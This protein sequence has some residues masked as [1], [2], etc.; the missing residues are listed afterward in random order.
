MHVEPPYSTLGT[1]TKSPSCPPWAKYERSR[2]FSKSSHQIHPGL[3]VSHSDG[4]VR[5]GQ[6]V[7]TAVP[8]RPALVATILAVPGARPLTT[9]VG[10]TVAVAGSRLVQEMLRPRRGRP[11]PSF[12]S[13][14]SC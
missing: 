2:S 7:I 10:E 1:R 12:T 6:T 14:L 8:F 11:F 13:A 9:P 3:G 5:V 4:S